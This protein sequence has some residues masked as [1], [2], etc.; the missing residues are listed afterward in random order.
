MNN[1]FPKTFIKHYNTCFLTLKG[2]IIN[3]K[4]FDNYIYI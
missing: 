2:L 1:K 4:T 3:F